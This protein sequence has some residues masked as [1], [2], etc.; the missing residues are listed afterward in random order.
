MV[1]KLAPVFEI[2]DREIEKLIIKFIKIGS[3]N[4]AITLNC[5]RVELIA[6]L[7]K[8]YTKLQYLKLIGNSLQ[9]VAKEMQKKAIH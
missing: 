1:A 6:V 9:L 2:C 3:T 8:G 4:Q 5:C 7:C